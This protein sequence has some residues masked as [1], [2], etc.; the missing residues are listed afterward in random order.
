ME[1]INE[2]GKIAGSITAILGLLALILF[3]PIKR[4]VQA[5]RDEKREQ[6]DF[7]KTVLSKLDDITDDIADLQYERLSQAHDFYTT[8]GWCPTSKKEQLCEMH[9]SYRA[10]GRNHLSQH[11]EE[12]IMRL[13]DKPDEN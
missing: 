1:Q 13:A 12:E 2:L 11:Y 6:A 8:R 7:R 10:K 9:K 3:N 4:R 5:R